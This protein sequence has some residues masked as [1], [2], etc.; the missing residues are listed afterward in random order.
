LPF[1]CF[2]RRRASPREEPSVTRVVVLGLMGQYPL[3]GMAWQV[4]HHMEGL[5]QLGCD[6]VYIENNGAPP[7]SPSR[8]A[9]GVDARE[10]LRFLRN[11]FRSFGRADKWAYFDCLTNRWSGLGAA[12]V[13]EWLTHADVVLNLCAASLPDA[14]ANRRGCLVYLET[15]PI[16]EQVKLASGDAKARAFVSAHDVHFTY[17]WNI[18][19]EG[20]RV[21]DGGIAWRHTHPPVVV[22]WWHRT[23]VA[24]PP[25]MAWRSIAT[26]RNEGKDV[27]IDGETYRW[28]KE[29]SFEIVMDLPRE[30][31]PGWLEL[32]LVAPDDAVW[33][34]FLR[35]GWRL[36][37][38]L[39]VSS[40]V[41]RYQRFIQTA[42]G[43]FSVEKDDQVRLQSGW[44]S[45][46]SVCFL[47][48]GRPCVLQ[49]TGFGTRFPVGQGVLAWR[50]LDEAR[51][52]LFEVGANP[53]RHRRY[54]RLLASEFF[55]ARVLL[56]EVLDAAGVG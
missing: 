36:R 14:L 55:E 47:A 33:Q 17:G 37:P 46:R 11:T 49:D 52:A 19:R 25:S 3:A 22:D 24:E 56:R 13:D 26:Y 10:N 31:L 8:Q 51:E 2:A 42:R 34:R 29:P 38:A 39:E 40:S 44:F 16:R 5:R 18:G 50:T 6:V 4:M 53:L 12:Q 41:T 20:C 35:A 9:I 27:V 32:A 21:P 30:P 7:Y 1:R 15:D 54:A 23:G 48:A 43:E 28:S 45:D